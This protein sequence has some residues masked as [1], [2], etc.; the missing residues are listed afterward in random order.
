MADGWW[1]SRCLAGAGWLAWLACWLAGVAGRLVRE[2]PRGGPEE[3]QKR[4][5]RGPAEAQKAR[6]VVQ[7]WAAIGGHR[8]PLAALRARAALPPK[9][10]LLY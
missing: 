7:P 8:R 1:L 9:P 4:P 6:G 3:A 5:R 2:R 10:P